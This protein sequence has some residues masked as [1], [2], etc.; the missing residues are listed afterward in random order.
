MRTGQWKREG[1]WRYEGIMV[2][3]GVKCKGRDGSGKD[4]EG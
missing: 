1:V 2:V 3:D 4:R